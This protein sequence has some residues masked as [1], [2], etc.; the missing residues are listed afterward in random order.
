MNVLITEETQLLKYYASE[1]F[2]KTSILETKN[3]ILKDWESL[4]VSNRI[5]SKLCNLKS[6]HKLEIL[7]KIYDNLLESK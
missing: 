3:I 7:H 1:T 2:F 5:G 6:L 4:W